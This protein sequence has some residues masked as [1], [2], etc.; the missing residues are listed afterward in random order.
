MQKND[1]KTATHHKVKID[2]PG[3]I[4][5]LA[6]SLYAESDVFIREMIQNAHDGIQRR[7]EAQKDQAPAGVIRITTN[8]TIGTLTFSDNGCGLTENE[9]HDYLATIGRSGT[10]DFR[11]RLLDTGRHMEVT[12]IGR[13]GIG[14]LSAFV[15]A[16]RV[17][18]ETR[19]VAAGSSAYRWTSDGQGDYTIEAATRAEPGTSVTLHITTEYRDMLDEEQLV[20]AVKKYADFIPV[21]IFINDARTPTNTVNAP[22]HRT[23][24]SEDQ[25]I[26][27]YWTFA[28]HR[29]PD[30]PLE[31]I[32]VDIR[33][34]LRVQ[35]ILYISDQHVP[36]IASA[37]LVDIYQAR[38]L[39]TA[40][41]RDLLPSWAKFVR[42]VIDSPDLL[43]TAAR[44]AI[45]Q[46]AASRGV[47]DKL[48]EVIVDHLRKL[49][50]RDPKKFERL[51][52]L[53]AYHVKGM[54]IQHDDLFDAICDLVPF[55][56]NRGLMNLR[57][58]LDQSPQIPGQR[59]RTIHYFSER[60]SAT[61]FYMLCNAKELLAIN[62]GYVFDEEF[63]RK[64]AQ[65]HADVCLHL[66]SVAG[67]DFLFEPVREDAA[68]AFRALERDFE[69]IMPHPHSRA[70][71]VR[72]APATLPAVTVLSKEGRAQRE[73][74]QVSDSAIVPEAIRKIV[75]DVLGDKPHVPVVVQ[76]NADNP[77]V[78]QLAKLAGTPLS[79]TEEYTAVLLAVYNNAILLAQ[80]LMTP[81]NA[82]AAFGSSNK[83]IR[84]L[85]D[86]TEQFK[87]TQ[88]QLTAMELRLREVENRDGSTQFDATKPRH[89]VC[90][91]SLPFKD[92]ETFAFN[93]VL[94]PALRVVLEQAPYFWQ[95]VRADEAYQ[96]E[97]VPDSVGIWLQR[98]DAYI[99]DISTLNANVMMELGFMQWEK[100][101]R[102]R[103]RLVLEREGAG[104]W[105]ANLG[106]FIK[107]RYP[108][109]D[110]R[111][112]VE[113]LAKSL[114]DEFAK[115]PAV[116]QLNRKKGA[117][118]LS[119][120][121]LKSEFHLE[122]DAAALLS[123]KFETMEAFADAKV[124]DIVPILT[125]RM[126]EGI[127]QEVAER[128]DI[129]KKSQ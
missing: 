29:F 9:I 41:N 15:A 18:V 54:A 92:H 105:L 47:R 50:R 40:G 96:G 3:L 119:T 32:P 78:Q 126:A 12:V 75:Q 36:D 100:R 5:L 46:D 93:S 82:Q 45:Q 20:R 30:L 128:L 16:S 24:P 115:I 129:F 114:A 59:Q 123:K 85:I 43:P 4:H 52:G 120:L 110:G 118:F 33:D 111:E 102:N 73:L 48:G 11:K 14:L 17:V 103:P 44:D 112:A 34:P 101:A 64:F 67:S 35:G 37:G 22:W 90:F 61:Q 51:L 94:L 69:G 8:H 72:F 107:V 53:H 13:F 81:E 56:T 26:A 122:T 117:H 6:K 27:E 42:G 76:L 25:R 55:E 98:A 95:I 89:I 39:I 1:H 57:R 23:F 60:G 63:L 38:M 65:R 10:D 127:K 77:T 71:T 70:Q 68:Q 21:N 106:G 74:R 49:A 116:K 124:V 113:D 19:S 88:A 84:L 99:A 80:H 86:Q 104:A 97:T 62:A 79:K 31:I 2:L 28:N 66:I 108:K 87:Q 58:Y 83:I 121:F 91:A 109:V 125:P 7:T